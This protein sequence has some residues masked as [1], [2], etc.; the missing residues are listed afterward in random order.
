MSAASSRLARIDG[1][2]VHYLLEGPESAPVIMLAHGLL[3]NLDMWHA[4]ASRLSKDW[5][6]LRYDLRGHG[7]T[8]ATPP[9]YSLA[10]LADDCLKLLDYLRLPRVHFIGSSLGGMIGQYL[11]AHAGERFLS[12]TLA[13]TTAKQSAAAVWQQRIDTALGPAGVAPL[14]EPTLQRW[15]TAEFLGRCSAVGDAMRK[16]SGATPP[17]G[18]AGCAAAVRDLDQ[19]R[20]LSHIRVPTLV[21]AGAHDMA[22][23]LA[24][25][26]QLQTHI[27]NARLVTLAAAHQSAVELPDSF[28]DHWRGFITSLNA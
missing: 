19:L 8:M 2:D 25:A 27:P 6:V 22:T 12:L 1:A 10:I 23:P 9:P 17:L 16:I 11:G 14:V 13:N 7:R 24:E 26:V 4:V 3:A 20:I 15:F 18:F 21:I 5:R 28:T